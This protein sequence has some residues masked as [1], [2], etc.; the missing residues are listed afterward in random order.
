MRSA[1]VVTDSLVWT[2]ETEYAL[3]VAAAEGVA[4]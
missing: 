1:L 3:A 2:A 4:V